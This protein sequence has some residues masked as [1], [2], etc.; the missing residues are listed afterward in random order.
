M[1]LG[2]HARAEKAF[3]FALKGFR[4]LSL[5][6]EIAL[7]ALDCCELLRL[8]GEWEE[9]GRLA[10]ETYTRFRELSGNTEAIAALSLILDSVRARKGTE[11]AIAA[12]RQMVEARINARMPE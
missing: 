12:A 2:A 1:K 8:F 10:F 7:V 3:R 6:W 4:A 5:P 11:A 9:L